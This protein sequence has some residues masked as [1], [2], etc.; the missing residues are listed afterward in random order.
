MN[1]LVFATNNSHKLAELRRMLGDRFDVV[2]LAD[3]GC[4]DDIPETADTFAGNAELKA[5]WVVERY[6]LP[7]VAD[8]SGLEVDALDGAPGVLSARFAGGSGHDSEA[9]NALLLKRLEGV[10]DRSARF[11]CVMVYLAPG[12]PP[13]QFDGTVE[14]HIVEQ[15]SGN[16][17]FGY[18]PLFRPLGWTDTFG[19]A[20]PER[21]DAISHRGCAARALCR[22]LLEK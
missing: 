14:G 8:D 17:G 13:H 5:R 6:G 11:R 15:P 1:R 3:I 22:F 4:H 18:D 12:E 19:D 9:N 21:K 16:G 10:A 7:C 2:G 20:T